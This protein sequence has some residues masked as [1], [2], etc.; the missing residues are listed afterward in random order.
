MISRPRFKFTLQPQAAA[1]VSTY[2]PLN[3]NRGGALVVRQPRQKRPPKK[4][5]R[6][7]MNSRIERANGPAQAGW[8][9]DTQ[10]HTEGDPGLA[11]SRNVSARPTHSVVSLL[12]EIHRWRI[13]PSATI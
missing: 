2:V 7:G 1:A 9:Y 13:A 4:R 6:Y 3:F 8:V 10:L 11:C 12:R 5:M